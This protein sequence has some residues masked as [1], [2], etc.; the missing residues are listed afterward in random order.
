MSQLK[1]RSV[2]ASFLFEF[3]HNDTALL[4]QVALFRRSGD[5]RT[6]QYITPTLCTLPSTNLFFFKFCFTFH[7]L[8]RG[9]LKA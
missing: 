3:P 7:V 2:A 6:Y 8:I 1:K 4:P 9:A 5:V